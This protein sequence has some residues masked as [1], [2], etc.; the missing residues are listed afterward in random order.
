[1]EDFVSKDSIVRKIWGRHD[2]VLLIFAGS[3][4]E[5]ALNKAVDWLYFTGKLPADPIGRLFSTVTYARNIVFSKNEKALAV[6]DTMRNIHKQ[7]E[8]N[9]QSTIPDWAYRD[10]LYMLID[11]SISSYEALER[12]LSDT[13]KEEVFDVFFRVGD[14]MGLSSLPTTFHAWLKSREIHLKEDLVASHYTQ[15]L[16][17]QY[18]KHLG[19]LRYQIM[20]ESQKLVIPETVRALLKLKHKSTLTPLLPIYKLIKRMNLDWFLFS[21]ILPKKYR[22][23][24]KALN[25]A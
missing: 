21:G 3:A 7:V 22:A 19:S 15:D 14:R 4:A 23:Q 12:K 20:V 16:F 18:K 8:S 25:Q 5:F 2:T 6:I 24:I 17:K 1:M 9:R 11:Y 10:V 13:E